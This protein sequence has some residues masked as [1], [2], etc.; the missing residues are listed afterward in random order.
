MGK[1]NVPFHSIIF[2]ASLMGS[3]KPWKL[4]NSIS[5]TEY[6]QYEGA[7]FSKSASTGIFCD[8]IS[9]LDIDSSIWRYYL[10]YNRP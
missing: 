5:A 2:P 3:R 1:D 6:L 4:V 8:V 10:I 7:K 9:S